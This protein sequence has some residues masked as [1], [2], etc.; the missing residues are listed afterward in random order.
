MRSTSSTSLASGPREARRRDATISKAART[1]HAGRFHR[2]SLSRYS[3]D[4]TERLSPP[5][6]AD[7]VGSLLRPP[8]LLE[9]RSSFAAGT[10]DAEGLRA[11]EDAAIRD[12]VALQEDLGFHDATDGE[13]RRTS[14]HM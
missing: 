12:A 13:F 8:D 4:M 7:H 10:L 5:F 11:I 2:H 1:H 3:F 9:A 6:R 14:W